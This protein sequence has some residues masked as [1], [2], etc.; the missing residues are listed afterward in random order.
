LEGIGDCQCHT[1]WAHRF[2]PQKA[3]GTLQ[4]LNRTGDCHCHAVSWATSF[5]PRKASGT[6]GSRWYRKVMWQRLI[7]CCDMHH[8]GDT[9]GRFVWTV[10]VAPDVSNKRNVCIFED[11]TRIPGR[12]GKC[13]SAT[14]SHAEKSVMHTARTPCALGAQ[15]PLCCR[16]RSEERLFQLCSCLCGSV[17]LPTVGCLASH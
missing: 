7:T 8:I 11:D 1:V 17:V 13:Q 14:Q 4:S 6:R 3:C 9:G 10:L 12:V 16:W 5:I 15:V 2:I